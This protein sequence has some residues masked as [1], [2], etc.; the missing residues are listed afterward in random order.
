MGDTAECVFSP[1]IEE[2]GQERVH[3]IQSPGKLKFLF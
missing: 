3:F 1:G 2:K